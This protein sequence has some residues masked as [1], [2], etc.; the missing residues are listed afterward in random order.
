M[1]IRTNLELI[2]SQ[3]PT[4]VKL[5]AV[6]KFHPKEAVEEAYNAG[7]RV[8]GESRVQELDGKQ[9][10]LPQDIEWHLIGHLQT[11]KIKYIVP[12]IHTI[13]SVDS[14]RLL[15]E[16]N[17]HATKA[18]RIINCLLEI[19][20]AQEDSK[21]GLT[22]D[23]CKDLLAQN[24]WQAL[25]NIKIAGV[26]GMATNTD[27]QEKVR[28]EFRSLKRFFDEVKNQFFE[29]D[30]AFC[31]ISMGMSHDYKIAIQEGST[32]IRVGSSIFGEREY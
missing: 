23:S 5:V 2:K 26:M 21:F 4:N 27:D 7:Q 31:E 8:F 14:G 16:I 6:S 1:G 12:Y 22:F 28:N 29:H 13:H 18:N 32:I 30:P 10:D 25:S 20:I 24:E 17:A 3:L 19:H 9:P 11:N 15:T